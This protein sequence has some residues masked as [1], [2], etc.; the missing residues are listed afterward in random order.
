[1]VCPGRGCPD[2]GIIPDKNRITS[3]ARRGASSYTG[4]LF[5]CK[6]KAFFG[7]LWASLYL[8]IYIYIYT[9][10]SHVCVLVWGSLVVWCLSCICQA[11]L[12]I[13]LSYVVLCCVALCCDLSY[14]LVSYHIIL[15]YIISLSILV[16][17]N[18]VIW[19]NMIWYG[20]IWIDVI[21]YA[22]IWSDMIWY[23]MTC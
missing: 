22:M 5:A 13:M 1:M 14:Q 10:V 2:T 8:Y 7:T 15:Y 4:K 19:Y 17:Y 21:G 12:R 6:S 11:G 20:T 3:S 9:Y 23:G 16:Y 18:I